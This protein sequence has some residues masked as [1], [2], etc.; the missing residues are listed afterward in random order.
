MARLRRRR[1]LPSN[2]RAARDF[3]SS[4]GQGEWRHANFYG[5]TRR[6]GSASPNTVGQPRLLVLRTHSEGSAAII[7]YILTLPGGEGGN[8][9]LSEKVSIEIGQEQA[10]QSTSFKRTSFTEELPSLLAFGIDWKLQ[11]CHPSTLRMSEI[12][13]SSHLYSPINN[14]PELG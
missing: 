2:E 12:A 3:F 7:I 5:P 1:H 14:N 6:V 13:L 10:K 4:H 8:S 9:T 11:R